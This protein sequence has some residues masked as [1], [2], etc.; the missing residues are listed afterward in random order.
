MV[1]KLELEERGVKGEW[2]LG[3]YVNGASCVW[4]ESWRMKSVHKLEEEQ[5]EVVVVISG[6]VERVWDCLEK[7]LYVTRWRKR[8]R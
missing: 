8:R 6:N 2:R 7:T 1:V 3:G 5:E 4:L